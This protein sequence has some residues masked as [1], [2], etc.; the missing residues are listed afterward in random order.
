MKDR[1][2]QL[3]GLNGSAS[4]LVGLATT[5]EKTE[6]FFFGERNEKYRLHRYTMPDG[7][8]YVEFLQAEQNSP[9][10]ELF[11]LA[12][13]DEDTGDVVE[14]SLWSEDDVSGG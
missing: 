4:Y 1:S 10:G 14:D 13:K 8:K 2:D 7:Q 11:F 9:E 3:K 12:L 5:K 6:D